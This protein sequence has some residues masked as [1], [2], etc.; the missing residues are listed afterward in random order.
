MRKY[1]IIAFIGLLCGC[2]KENG[3]RALSCQN[4]KNADIQVIGQPL[5]VGIPVDLCCQDN[6]LFVLAHSQK[7]WLHIYDKESGQ[8]LSENIMIGRGPGEGVNFVSMDYRRDEQNLYVF[9]MVLRKTVV[10]HLGGISGTARYIREMEHPSEGVI[11]KCYTLPDGNFLYEGYLAGSDKNVRLT[12]SDGKSSIESYSEYPGISNEE[13]KYAFM[14]GVSKGD[15]DKGLY[16]CGTMFG[17]V[18]ECFD[19]N[20]NHIQ[21]KSLRLIDPPEMDLSGAGIQA[22]KGKKYGFMTFC[23]DGDMIYANYMDTTVPYKFNHIVSF[24]WKGRERVKYTASQNILRLCPG[25]K[26]GKEL[27]CIVS[28]PSSEFALA[29]LIL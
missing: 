4:E 23:L 2:A 19:V 14:L 10:Y 16:V 29:K 24:D 1:I 25:E 5:E 20:E 13:D 17:S 27:Y 3:Y 8:L 7:Y 11:R 9:D 6:C 12:L 22:K 28:S 15:P 26:T 21:P 18:L